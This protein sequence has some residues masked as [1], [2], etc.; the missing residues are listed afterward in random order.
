MNDIVDAAKANKK[1]LTTLGEAQNIQVVNDIAYIR[2]DML[3]AGLK[4]I[5]D[6]INQT[7]DSLINTAFHHHRSLV[8]EKKRHSEPVEQARKILKDKMLAYHEKQE[9]LRRAKEREL[10]EEARKRAESEVLAEATQLESNGQR[11]DAEA[12]LNTPVQVPTIIIPKQLPKTST[13]FQTRWDYRITD[14]TLIPR[15]Y[16][17]VD[18][19]KLGAFARATKGS[20][21]VPGVEFFSKRS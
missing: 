21:T 7:F 15:S 8:T 11:T 2:A 12:I 9:E 19:V 3:R 13:V 17:R 4:E 16:L 6:Q 20:V 10:Q 18:E 14:A 1:A 5:E